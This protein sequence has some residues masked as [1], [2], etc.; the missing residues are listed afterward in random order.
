MAEYLIYFNQQWVGDHTQEVEGPL[1]QVAM[2]VDALPS[3]AP[4]IGAMQPSVVRLN[5]RPQA[6]TVGTT[7]GNGHLAQ[8]PLWKSRFTRELRPGIA[9]VDRL[10]ES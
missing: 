8:R 5:V 7:D 10:E 3:G 2:G 4:V 1:P 9:A 6:A